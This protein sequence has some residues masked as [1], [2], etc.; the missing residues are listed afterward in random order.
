MGP[1]R[2]FFRATPKEGG[3]FEDWKVLPKIAEAVR[4]VLLSPRAAATFLL[5]TAPWFPPVS[6]GAVEKQLQKIS[7][8]PF[9]LASI[10]TSEDLETI[11]TN[12]LKALSEE[13]ADL[14]KKNP[15]YLKRVWAL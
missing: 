12:A 2:V 5:S 13:N 9:P 3:V 1:C 15:E 6:G 7:I 11:M 4:N 14:I 10:Q 8:V